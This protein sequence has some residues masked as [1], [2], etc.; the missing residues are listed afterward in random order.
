[1]TSVAKDHILNR[2]QPFKK[3][4]P[5]ITK[6]QI[7]GCKY[8]LLYPIIYLNII[9]Y[10]YF[11][12]YWLLYSLNYLSIIIYFCFFLIFGYCIILHPMICIFV[13][14]GENLL[15]G[16]CRMRRRPVRLVSYTFLYTT[17]FY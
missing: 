15:T 2:H 4:S 16:W 7:I 11:F 3:F 1:M 5:K 13:I 10:F 8:F 12:I 17:D 9:V 14:L 6:I